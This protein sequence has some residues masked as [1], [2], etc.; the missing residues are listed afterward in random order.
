MSDA[1]GNLLFYTN[2]CQVANRYNVV[3]PNGDGLNPGSLNAQVCPW[4]GYTVPQGAI[5]LPMPGD[6]TRFC[7][8]HMAGGYEPVR[9]LALTRLQ[10]SMI[11]MTLDGGLGDI[12]NK[13]AILLMGDFGSFTAIRHGN[14]RDW[15]IIVPDFGN[16]QWHTILLTPH[17]FDIKTPQQVSIVNHG[18]EHHG[19]TAAALD[20]S[21]V[22]NWGDCKVS[23]LNFDRCS[24]LF[25]N[26]LELNAPS[27]WV[28]G[29]GLAFS[30]SG[31]YLYSTSQN[32][33]FRT[34]LESLNPKL[35]TMRYS[36]DPYLQSLYYVPGN[37][38]HY[39]TNGPDGNIYGNIPSRAKFLHILRN[40]DGP[41]IG[42]IQFIPQ[43]LSL[44]IINARTLPNLPNYRLKGLAGS[45]CDTLGISAV[46]NLSITPFSLQVMPNPNEGNFQITLPEGHYSKL[47]I[48]NIAGQLVNHIDITVN[49]N[50]LK[51]SMGKTSPGVYWAA[52]YDQQG[53]ILNRTKIIVID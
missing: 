17:G 13:N 29:G 32:V 10:C 15:W 12:A 34:D 9:K 39:L 6:S 22:A 45:S 14:G 53:V 47:R 30:A 51:I 4:K 42:D 33:L 38:F 2:G 28:P 41:G 48:F 40:A 7:L 50:V 8:I 20:G 43:G 36:L 27:H 35:D 1:D 26:L 52:L 25:S 19:A 49:Q 5:A 31:R 11:D 37:T 46:H 23:I 21:K 44:P 24:G 3:M 16:A 18:C